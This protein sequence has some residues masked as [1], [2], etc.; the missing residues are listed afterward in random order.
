M[1]HYA[2]VIYLKL[3]LAYICQYI[4]V[5][6]NLNNKQMV[7]FSVSES[8]SEMKIIIFVCQSL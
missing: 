8:Q 5:Q 7:K 4:T 2:P 3:V 6:F 1:K